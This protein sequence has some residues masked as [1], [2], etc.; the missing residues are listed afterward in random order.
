MASLPKVPSKFYQ[1]CRLCLTVVSDT[2]ELVSLSVFGRHNGGCIA[3]ATS[4]QNDG[5]ATSNSGGVIVKTNRNTEPCNASSPISEHLANHSITNNASDNEAAAD[6]N[7]PARTSA[8]DDNNNFKIDSDLHHSDILERINT[9]LSITVSTSC[10]SP[11]YYM[12]IKRRTIT[13]YIYRYRCRE[14]LVIFIIIVTSMK[15]S[16]P[17][18]YS[19]TVADQRH[20]NVV[21][22][23]LL[24]LPGTHQWEL[25]FW[26]IEACR[27]VVW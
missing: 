26:L 4:A 5:V 16:F 8:D 12:Y 27:P 11:S 13:T 14:I 21:S 15:R 3:T 10:L 25:E 23:A 2:S 20:C 24:P 9:F 1:V 19:K 7:G 18:F 6:E 22:F 17:Q